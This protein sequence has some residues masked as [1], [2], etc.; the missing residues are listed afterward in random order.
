MRARWLLPSLA[1]TLAALGM[2]PLPLLSGEYSYRCQGRAGY[3][4]SSDGTLTPADEAGEDA[5][6]WLEDENVRFEISR[7]TGDV[8][9]GPFDTSNRDP[10][11]VARGG[12]GNSFRVLI[13]SIGSFQHTELL[14]VRSWAET[15]QK[16]FVGVTMF[17]EVYTGVCE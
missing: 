9:G 8:S 17:G 5:V 1:I 6:G 3:V 15:P 12:N 13:R 2:S 7:E 14:M 16:P 10:E 4:L 11:L